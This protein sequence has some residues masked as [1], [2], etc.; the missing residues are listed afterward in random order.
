MTQFLSQ[1]HYSNES[2][3][4]A[5]AIVSMFM[6]NPNYTWYQFLTQNSEDD[7]DYDST[8]WDDP[9][10]TFPQMDLPPCNSFFNAF[11]KT[12]LS[13]NLITEMNN[14][15]V[16]SLVGGHPNTAHIS[17]SAGYYNACSLRGSR[18]LNYFV[19]S[20][21]ANISI[22]VIINNG[23]QYTEKG[24]DNK[25]YILN[26]T[27]FNTYMNKAFGPPT[28]Q[29]KNANNTALSAK[30]MLDFFK[31]NSNVKG[32]YNIVNMN[33]TQA[34]YSGHVDLYINGQ[35]LSGLDLLPKGGVYKIEIWE[36]N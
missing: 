36:L 31:S 5:A 26:A 22:P 28:Y 13:G 11:P 19:T 30:Q 34:T 9:N 3:G 27:A 10:L 32:I 6:S 21:G 35:T 14:N 1:Y 15:D 12:I 25:N 8:F 33:P 7:G 24:D 20:S 18:G 2:E 23:H 29:L 17:G 16:Y 4:F